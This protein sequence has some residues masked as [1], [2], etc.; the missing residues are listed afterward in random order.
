MSTPPSLP[1]EKTERMGWFDQQF[2]QTSWPMLIALMIL[3]TVLMWIFSG[4]GWMVTRDPVA[5]RKAKIAFVMS[6]LLIA[7]CILLFV[8]LGP[9]PSAAIHQ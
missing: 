4:I 9:P 1:S 5:H 7:G 6:T 2:T 3:F 8:V